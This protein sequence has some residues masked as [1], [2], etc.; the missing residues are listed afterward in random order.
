MYY[1]RLQ[2][3]SLIP[4]PFS[5][6]YVKHW[7]L[8]EIYILVW[9]TLQS[10]RVHLRKGQAQFVPYLQI[11]VIQGPFVADMDVCCVT[12]PSKEL[13]SITYVASIS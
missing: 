1:T 4:S 13:R 11:V 3:P 8:K 12:Q 9:F 10:S 2:G 5:V 6:R 7:L